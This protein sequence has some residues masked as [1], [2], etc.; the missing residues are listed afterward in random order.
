MIFSNELFILKC[1]FEVPIGLHSSI[2]T[3]V[4]DLFHL[5]LFFTVDDA[6]ESM[7]VEI[8]RVFEGTGCLNSLPDHEI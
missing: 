3:A 7:E 5:V 1:N 8:R 2:W 4:V 6:A